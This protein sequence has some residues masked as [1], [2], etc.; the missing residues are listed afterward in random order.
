MIFEMNEGCK[1]GLTN[2]NPA[3]ETKILIHYLIKKYKIVENVPWEA[4]K[5]Y[6]LL[7]FFVAKKIKINERS[8][9]RY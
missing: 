7:P 4:A 1:S 9:T 5:N 3:K 8:S 6:Y 2:T